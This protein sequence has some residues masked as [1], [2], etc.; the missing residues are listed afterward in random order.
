[1]SPPGENPLPE[2]EGR[3]RDH[4]VLAALLAVA[5]LLTPIACS[6]AATIG[7]KYVVKEPSHLP[8]ELLWWVGLL[9]AAS[10][11]FFVTERVARRAIP[12][13]V[14]LKMGL[15]FPGQAPK[16]LAIARR[17]G[18]V[19]D[20]SRRLEEAR[21]KGVTDEPSLAAEKIVALAVSLGAHDRVTRG[22]AERV[23]AYTDLIADEMHL[24]RER[25]ERLR[26]SALLHDIGKLTI[27]P[28]VLNK[29]GSLS[30]EEWEI[31][32]QHP[33][34]GA[35]ITAPLA[36]WLGEWS[37]TIAEHHERYDGKGYPNGLAGRDIST[38]GRIVAVAD[39]YDVM[40]SVRSY[41]RPLSPAVARTELAACAGT[42]FDPEVVRLFLGVSLHRL[43]A[44]VPLTW[45]SSFPFG[46]LGVRLGTLGTAGS[47][48]LLAAFVAIPAVFGLAVV[49][50]VAHASR[51]P[52]HTPVKTTSAAG[53]DAVVGGVTRGRQRHA[54]ASDSA[55]G[56]SA[57]TTS[58][59]LAAANAVTSTSEGG[60]PNAGAAKGRS[61]TT[62]TAAATSAASTTTTSAGEHPT[63]SVPSSSGGSTT[64]SLATGGVTTT[65]P[66]STTTTTKPGSSTTTTTGGAT[67][68]TTK[69]GSSTTTTTAATTTTTT[70]TIPPPAAPT[71]LSATGSCEIVVLVPEVT[72]SWTPSTTSSVTSYQVYR[73]TSGGAYSSLATVNGRTSSGY[74][75]TAVNGGTTYSY[76]VHAVAPSGSTSTGPASVT[77]PGLCL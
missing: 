55:G 21:A 49:G 3:W 27:H 10:A 64:T 56:D 22:H 70:T 47:N 43:R 38:G 52:L 63:T 67:T 75:D 50:P 16:R 14:L 61:A 15:V 42:Q 33:L 41:K 51:T 68:T 46:N 23:R 54:S 25:R 18:S 20:L 39:S 59:T 1:V 6:I 29:P 12:L 17:A 9:A 58:T 40:T 36:E 26:W 71:G 31:L 74:T 35:R 11:V 28:E 8:G 62:T 45:L 7:F 34:E 76:E 44:A 72:L 37:Q 73:S 5:I 32:R 53:T 4:R 24:S 19:R 57:S 65:K 30:D 66:G 48:A 13:T 77:T 60:T 69:P 2:P